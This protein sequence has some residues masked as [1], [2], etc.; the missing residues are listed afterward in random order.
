MQCSGR[1]M[2]G[3]RRCSLSS[4]YHSRHTLYL[5]CNPS[6]V[7]TFVSPCVHGLLWLLILIWYS[8]LASLVAD[9]V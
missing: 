9:V 8:P 4:V 6:F 7:C 1:M 5:H 3:R 2:I